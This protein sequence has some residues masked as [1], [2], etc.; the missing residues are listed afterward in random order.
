MLLF[1]L[2][3]SIRAIRVIRGSFR[4]QRFSALSAEAG[5]WRVF[6]AA[7]VADDYFACCAFSRWLHPALWQGLDVAVDHLVPVSIIQSF[8]HRS[9][10]LRVPRLPDLAHA[11]AA[12]HRLQF[13]IADHH[14]QAGRAR[15]RGIRHQA[16]DAILI[17]RFVLFI[18]DE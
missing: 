8:G 11:P 10:H 12:Q 1:I 17:P 18:D 9:Q 7:T 3:S 6:C 5:G 2:A 15:L 14:A 16:G 4:L 13:E